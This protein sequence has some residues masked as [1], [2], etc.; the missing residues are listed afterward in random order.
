MQSSRQSTP[1]S[2][3]NLLLVCAAC[4]GLPYIYAFA[5]NV[6]GPPLDS[7]DQRTAYVWQCVAA[8][9]ATIMVSARAK[10]RGDEKIGHSIFATAAIFGTLTILTVLFRGYYSNAVLGTA[11][12]TSI[13]LG[14]TVIGGASQRKNPRVALIGAWH[15]LAARLPH[16]VIHLPSPQKAEA[17]QSFDIILTGDLTALEP[18]W[19]EP[20]AH[21]MVAGA[22]IR[23]IAEYAEE[24][25]G[26]V[27]IEHFDITHLSWPRI[28]S[29]R[30]IKR[31]ADIL[32]VIVSSPAAIAITAISSIAILATMGRP[33]LFVQDRVGLDGKIFRMF[34]LRT[35]TQRLV[36][37]PENATSSGDPRV[38]PLGRIL[39]RFRI[40]EL[41][42]LYN[43]LKGDM[44]VVGPR[45]EQPSLTRTYANEMPAFLYRCLV[46]PGITGWAQVRSGYA[47]D[48]AETREKLKND[49]YYI[50]YFSAALDVQILIRTVGT[51]LGGGG[52]R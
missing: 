44:S 48:L 49:L 13:I 38:T 37:S 51:L 43:V 21:A 46:R 11:L 36:S 24:V 42:Q 8:T 52:V 29:Y 26:I 45:P 27:S 12:I 10:G 15:S 39:R 30:K 9:I 17:I 25:E 34:K 14:L 33:V 2:S 6:T 41:P 35:M 40:D 47:T 3:D 18:I 22:R 7:F 19:A 4:I 16:P 1:S 31:I 28:H 20:L 32:I 5:A 23:H 50:K